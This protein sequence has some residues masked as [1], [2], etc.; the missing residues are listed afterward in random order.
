M[1]DYILL[2]GIDKDDFEVLKKYRQ[3]LSMR[4]VPG[5]DTLDGHEFIR[6][7]KLYEGYVSD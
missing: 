2:Y 3:K 5:I 1:E 4:D 7:V 6:K